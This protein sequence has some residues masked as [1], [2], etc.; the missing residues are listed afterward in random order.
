HRAREAGRRDASGDRLHGRRRERRS[1]DRGGR[2]RRGARR[3]RARGGGGGAVRLV[4]AWR[5]RRGARAGGAP[6]QGAGRVAGDPRGSAVST[7]AETGGEIPVRPA[8]VVTP[9]PK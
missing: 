5:S 3:R 8:K 9:R 7:A 6:P 4:E 1:R 2:A